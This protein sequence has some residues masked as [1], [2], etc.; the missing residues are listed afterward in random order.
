MGPAQ[1]RNGIREGAT[2]LGP[3]P[4]FWTGHIFSHNQLRESGK[5]NG[6]HQKTSHTPC[7]QI[8]E[9]KKKGRKSRAHAP[10]QLALHP[11]GPKLQMSTGH[12]LQ[13]G[14]G[15]KMCYSDCQGGVCGTG[16]KSLCAEITVFY[17]TA[18]MTLP[19]CPAP[20]RRKI[21][22]VNRPF[23]AERAGQQDVLFGLP[24]GCLWDREQITLCRNHRFLPHSEW[25]AKANEAILSKQIRCG[26]QG[27]VCGTVGNTAPN[28]SANVSCTPQAQNCKCQQA[29]LCRTGRATRCAI[30]IAK[31]VSVG[32][33]TNH[34][35]PKSPFFTPPPK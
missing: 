32:P 30:Q 9:K 7:K 18:Q 10:N 33:G 31:G 12:S 13:N 8:V 29:I 15:N 28:D 34:F 25:R 21:A 22:N 3:E 16:N 11:P 1:L 6:K 35:V 20:P 26:C 4:H 17:P 2:I 24:R 14:Q 27:G 19:T 23:S 5:L